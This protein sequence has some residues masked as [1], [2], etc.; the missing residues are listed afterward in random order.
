M[1]KLTAKSRDIKEDLKEMRKAGEL[2]AVFYGADKKTTSISVSKI[3]FKKVWLKAGESSTV[4]ITTPEGKVNVLIHDV[5]VDPVTDEPIHIDFLAIDMNKKI[6]VSVP[7][8]FE[9]V[10]EVVK[11]GT[12][13]L[14][15]VAHEI[16][17]EA[18]PKDLPHNI[19]VDIS[20]LKTLHDQ[21]LISDLKVPA[22]VTILGE[23][24]E[25]IASIAVQVEEVEEEASP[26]DLSAIEVE[27]KGKKEEEATPAE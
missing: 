11:N 2:P 10:S 16:E 25:V 21:V 4:E 3:E 26:V 17:V 1:L 9:G 5:Q 24:D 13:T 14:V 12:G 20:K 23:A 15:K 27:K 6:T 19:V 7:L 8:E 22:G 18:L